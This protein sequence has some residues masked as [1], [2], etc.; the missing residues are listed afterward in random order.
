MK[1]VVKTIAV[2]L[3]LMI[4]LSFTAYM[5]EI[6]T[7]SYVLNCKNAAV[8]NTNTGRFV[9]EKDADKEVSIAS[10][11]KIMTAICVIENCDD[12]QQ[13]VEAKLDTLLT[14]GNTGMV[15][16]NLKAGEKM[17]VEN[18]LYCL[19]LPSAADA[20]VVLADFVSGSIDGFVALMNKK[21]EELSMTNTHY[22]NTHG[23]D[24]DGHYST[25]RDLA[26]LT[27]YALKNETFR[28]IVSTAAYIVPATNLSAARNIVT[29]NYLMTSASP[30]YYEYVKGVKTGYTGDAGRCLVSVAEKDGAEYV[31]VVLGCD[32]FQD[33]GMIGIK[34]FTDSIYLYEKTFGEYSYKTVYKKDRAVAQVPIKCF[35]IDD[36]V[37]AVLRED[38]S[39]LVGKNEKV[40]IK[41][42]LT[43]EKLTSPVKKG[44]KLGDGV[45]YLGKEKIATVDIVAERDV[46]RDFAKMAITVLIC[47]LILIVALAVILAVA[48][49]MRKQ[50]RKGKGNIKKN[51]KYGSNKRKSKKAIVVILVL[52]IIA[53]IALAFFVKGK[54]GTNNKPDTA[55]T[56]NV[57]DLG[58]DDS[59][60]GQNGDTDTEN[61]ESTEDPT[62]NS[63]ENADGQTS[64]PVI[65]EETGRQVVD[66]SKG[67]WNLVIV[68][69]NIEYTKD[70]EP[71]LKEVCPGEGYNMYMDER[72]ADHFTEMYNAAKE[73]GITLTPI[74]GYRSY[75][76]QEKNWKARIENEQANGYNYEEA[77]KRA[78]EVILPPGTS[79]H[80]IGIAMDIG[81][82]YDSFANTKEYEWLNEHAAEYGFILRYTDEWYG[83]TGIVPEPWH[84]RYVGTEYS[85]K[86]KE[87]GLCLE[88]Y[89]A[90]YGAD[91]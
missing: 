56:E 73:D 89:V 87:S 88:D 61:N 55:K 72:A 59:D 10:V 35:G 45:I 57:S 16:A 22:N 78:S 43:N 53:A 24:S 51:S 65:N 84:W 90:K 70:Y 7:S 80:N 44:D 68:N 81:S 54:S 76:L 9:F 15:T 21:A 48:A 30:Y 17:S 29:T 82:L 60:E 14:I 40:K 23:L 12:L 8:L 33:N 1:K 58:A 25:A 2:A 75:D 20:S 31:A 19:L 5:A 63:A 13:E 64:K 11:T 86:I 83:K 71:K 49:V 91:R 74:S 32:A 66:P 34:H 36:S 28:K 38:I 27:A 85:Q 50:S 47:L 46:D 18:L 69:A 6:D 77:V 62:E 3:A 52:A 67:N 79:E 26:N 39:Y 4:M 37:N 42:E 41:A